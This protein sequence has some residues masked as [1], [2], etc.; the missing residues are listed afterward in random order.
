[1]R[2][3]FVMMLTL[4]TLSVY[5]QDTR[6]SFRI[7]QLLMD[8]TRQQE[9]IAV[10]IKGDVLYLKEEIS[11]LG[12][13]VKFTAG[14]IC[15]A[16][17]SLA[18]ISTLSGD[19]H[20]QRI[21]EGHV[22]LQTMN[23]KMLINNKIDLVHSGA[24]PLTQ[25]YDGKDVVVGIIDTG[26]DF[27]HPDFRDSTGNSRIL[28]IWDHLLPTS[29]N[30]PQLYGYGQQFSKAMID[31]G[32]ATAHI[33][34]T[35]HGT[36]V[37]GIATANGDTL[38]MFKGAAP[39]ADI[40]AVSL[41][42]NQSDDSWLSTVADAVDYIFSKAD[43]LG[44]PCVINISAGTYLGSHDGKDL[45]S[46]SIDNLITSQN[47]RM[48]VAAAGN[49]GNYPIHMRH[50][51]N[52]DTAFTWF[53]VNGSNP[54]YI[55]FWADTADLNNVNFTLG[56]DKASPAFEDRAQLNWTS[57]QSKLGI[58]GFDTLRSF[59]G[60]RIATLQTYGQLVGGRYSM[61][62][63]II[64]DSISYYFRLMSKGTGQLDCWSFEMIS[65]GLPAASAYP[66]IIH[67]VAPDF[68]QNICS[69]FQCSEV[70]L[71]VGQYV[72]RNNYIDVNGNLQTFALTEGNIAVSSSRGPTRDG[73]TKPDITSTGEMT[74]ASC[75]MSSIAWF[76]AN[77]P[78]KLA[79]GGLHVRDGG[80]SSAAPAVSGG[81]AL[82]L[83]AHPTASWQD[84]RNRV[85][86]C[87]AKDNFTGTSLP[88]N[89]YG[90]G[91]F[92][93]F[94]LMNGC[95][96]LGTQETPGKQLGVYPNPVSEMLTVR[97]T[98]NEAADAF[99]Q[100]S[101][102]TGQIVYRRQLDKGA[103]KHVVD[104]RLFPAGLYIISLGSDRQMPLSARFVVTR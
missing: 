72:S 104:T 78:F 24:S 25:G 15:S 32:N 47:G 95:T 75:K 48:V 12:G 3:I 45:Q 61:V 57:I 96:A 84:I 85:L 101:T 11:H 22:N 51:L 29:T 73:R 34:A 46:L 23:D 13:R 4:F 55:E 37:A 53:F 87:S 27:S 26:I 92:D 77:Q 28:W 40:I 7:Q 1:M 99:I 5:A 44:K 16:E 82:Y 39:K 97:L 41:D 62:Y 69:S 58:I 42:F 63:Y 103:T 81:I 80:T 86:L 64:P 76:L 100:I 9:K 98:E 14:N 30:T 19:T 31:A 6:L 35:A 43:S 88:D 83:Q 56:A 8:E 50:S 49:A 54:V 74:L 93:A 71:C 66:N 33:D 90:H 79:Q 94:A 17:L 21:E 68:Q 67:Y 70:T 102:V 20:V 2:K 60:N 65:N 52:N 10:F 89:T 59:S 18:A 36:H 91:K 38:P